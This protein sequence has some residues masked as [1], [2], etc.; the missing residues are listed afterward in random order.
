MSLAVP[1]LA[2]SAGNVTLLLIRGVGTVLLCRKRL[3][4]IVQKPGQQWGNSYR[5][6][7]TKVLRED[8]HYYNQTLSKS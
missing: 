6:W 4:S 1:Y 3:Q 7:Y 8:V 2:G 5:D